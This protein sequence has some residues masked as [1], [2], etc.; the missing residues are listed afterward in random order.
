[1]CT[2]NLPF[3]LTNLSNSPIPSIPEANLFVWQWDP[4]K[5]KGGWVQQEDELLVQLVSTLGQNWKTIA[6]YFP[7]RTGKQCRE[8]YINSLDPNIKSTPWKEEEDQAIIDY[9]QN[10]GNKWSEVAKL[11]PGRTANSIKNRWHSNL[12]RKL[13]RGEPKSQPK[14]LKT[15]DSSLENIQV[16]LVFQNTSS[17]PVSL[18]S[19]ISDEPF[20]FNDPE[21]LAFSSKDEFNLDT[22][23]SDTFSSD[24]DSDSTLSAPSS[25][26]TIDMVLF[27]GFGFEEEK[28]YPQDIQDLLDFGNVNHLDYS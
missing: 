28:L 12:K 27:R 18:S 13:E 4:K 9:H 26:S 21:I 15:S 22:I 19:L 24:S 5:V 20:Q 16:P 14:R 1:M 2:P 6:S 8:R 11:L 17:N 3:V 7:S 23:S 25:P 10:F